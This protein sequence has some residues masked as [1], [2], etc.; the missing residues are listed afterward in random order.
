MKIRCNNYK[1][2]IVAIVFLY[3]LMGAVSVSNAALDRASAAGM[4]AHKALY[5]IRLSSKKSSVNISNITGKMFYEWQPSCDAWVSTHRFDMTYEYM[6]TPSVRVTSEF[7]TYESFDGKSFDFTMQRKTGDIVLEEIR[8][9]AISDDN[10]AVYS[11]PEDLVFNLPSGSLFPTAH[12][13]EVLGRVKNNQRYYNQVLFDGSD[14]D[15][16]V[17]INS[18]VVG[19]VTYVP[20]E[21]YAKDIDISLLKPQGWNMR[22]AF[23]PLNNFEET[24]DYEMSL[25]FHENGVI[26]DMEVD[27]GDFSVTQKLLAI[28]RLDSACLLDSN[29]SKIKS[30]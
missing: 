19:K 4:V 24:S 18:F 15:G 5:D 26:S 17:D 9:K 12:S 22:L 30:K 3:L 1:F 14:T 7:S 25:T 13:L 21:K 20:S 11:M 6:E 16:P 23:F 10:E 28:E 29:N 2:S 27:Y 8:G